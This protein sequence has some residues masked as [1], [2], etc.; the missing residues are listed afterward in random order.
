MIL[1]QLVCVLKGANSEEDCEFPLHR[2]NKSQ[3]PTGTV[4]DSMIVLQHNSACT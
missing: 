1:Y 2:R 3:L 4:V